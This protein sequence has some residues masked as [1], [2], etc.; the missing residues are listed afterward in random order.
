[1]PL[2]LTCCT[3]SW[4]ALDRGS[5]HSSAM[6]WLTAMWDVSSSVQL[7]MCTTRVQ[8][9]VPSELTRLAT[10]SLTGAITPLRQGCSFVSQVLLFP[11]M[12]PEDNRPAAPVQPPPAAETPSAAVSGT[13]TLAQ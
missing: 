7:Y 4:P 12:K 2:T 8:P 11:A 3:Y 9:G 1:M 10:A 6:T 5:P 13:G